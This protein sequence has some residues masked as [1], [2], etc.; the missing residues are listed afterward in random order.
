MYAKANVDSHSTT[1]S[2]AAGT[3]L[4]AVDDYY[5]DRSN[6][7]DTN[8][9]IVGHLAP[10][11]GIALK[12]DPRVTYWIKHRDQERRSTVMVLSLQVR[13]LGVSL[14]ILAALSFALGG[15]A[16]AAMV[17][18]D[19]VID[20]QRA[21]KAREEIKALAHRPELAEQLKAA[22]VAPD[23][24]DARVGAMTDAEV[25]AVAQKLAKLPAGG[26]IANNDLIVILLLII[27]IIV[28]V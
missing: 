17:G 28:L 22:G 11:C 7:N 26:A 8:R 5:A 15:T 6:L 1:G 13:R 20:S 4:R 14:L 25:L 9:H 27:L 10:P 16:Q 3:A 24:V 23:Q 2:F 21:E 12:F 19:N 18:T